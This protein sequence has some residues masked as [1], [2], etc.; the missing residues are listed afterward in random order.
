[1]LLLHDISGNYVLFYAGALTSIFWEVSTLMELCRKYPFCFSWEM[2]TLMKPCMQYPIYI[3]RDYR[4]VLKH[5]HYRMCSLYRTCSFH[6]MCC[7]I[8]ICIYSD[9]SGML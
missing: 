8:N 5:I 9:H 1:M 7:L 3:Y 4:D 2:S 6:R